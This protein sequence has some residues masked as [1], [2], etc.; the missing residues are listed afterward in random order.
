MLDLIFL[1]QY[2]NA[3]EASS[4]IPGKT[5]HL[6]ELGVLLCG[7]PVIILR[8]PAGTEWNESWAFCLTRYGICQIHRVYIKRSDFLNEK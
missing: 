6:M 2:C 4:E 1:Q 7:E 3:W 8:N 5:E